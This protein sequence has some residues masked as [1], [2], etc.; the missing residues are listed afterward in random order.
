M[1]DSKKNIKDG[2]IFKTFDMFEYIFFAIKIN[3]PISKGCHQI[4]I[5]DNKI[6]I[7][8]TYNN[9]IL[10]LNN[11]YELIETIFCLKEINSL[12][13]V[14]YKHVN[15]LYIDEN[16]IYCLFHNE[17]SKTGKNSQLCRIGKVKKDKEIIDTI[18]GCAHNIVRYNNKFLICDSLGSKIFLGDTVF[19]ELEGFTRGL[20]IYKDK[21]FMG[22]SQK[23][24]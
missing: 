1:T 10:I 13:D 18:F 21:L 4:V 22:E 15:S 5:N 12:Q 20:L 3:F 19:L 16:Y 8:D 17:T 23:K 24:S 2:Y 7:T 6:Y 14:N 11:K 9:K